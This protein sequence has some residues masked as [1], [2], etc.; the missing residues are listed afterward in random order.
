MSKAEKI[1]FTCLCVGQKGARFLKDLEARGWAPTRIVSYCQ[2]DDA[3]NSYETI[4][5]FARTH[6]IELENNTRPRLAK[7][8]LAFIVGWQF[9]VK[10]EHERL[11]VFHDSLLPRY[12]G[13]APTV[14][15]LI[16]GEKEIG[17]TALKPVSGVD[18][19]PVY[20]Q[21]A[22]PITYPIKIKDAL[23]IQAGAM[24]ALAA[25]LLA[26]ETGDGLPRPR[27]Q[28]EADATF[29]VWRDQEDYHINW[30]EPATRIARM[31]DAVGSPYE[32]ARTLYRGEEVII[33]A[34]EVIADLKFEIRQ[35]GK[36]WSLTDGIPTVICGTGLLKLHDVTSKTGA[37]IE[38]KQLR[39][40]FAAKSREK[41]NR[42]TQ[43]F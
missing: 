13:F 17:V 3:A 33:N 21:T 24:A 37:A 7:D 15:A 32:G 28:T 42:V 25:K 35:P 26:H 30:A 38:F 34:A 43:F 39:S 5:S 10:G 16:N 27:P 2:K 14:S 40:R 6:C 23:D 1:D 20:A 36:F 31:I 41:I 9:F 19:G 11:I 29:S 12:R 18:A 4:E 8:E 22:I